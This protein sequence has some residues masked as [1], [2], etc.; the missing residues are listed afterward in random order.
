MPTYRYRL[1]GQLYTVTLE[2]LPD[3][4]FRASIGDEVY[5][6]RAIAS[7]SDPALS[8][9]FDE[10]ER[11]RAAIAVESSGTR[12][13]D[14]NGEAF[15]IEA[16]TETTVR[17]SNRV[18]AGTKGDLTAQM[19]GQVREVAV[20]DGETVTR[21][22]TLI[23]LEAMKMEMRLTAPADGTVRRVLVKVGEIVERGQ[24]LIE[25]A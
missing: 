2:R 6:F 24:R 11:A 21:G 15:T 22:Q 16:E 14:V 1:D 3:G 12:W 8:L 17:R 5:L 18:K 7:E 19:P 4:G 10:G 25:L 13:I 9:E 23:V 20:A